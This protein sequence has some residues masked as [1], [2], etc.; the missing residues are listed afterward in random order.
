MNTFEVNSLVRWAFYGF[1]FSIPI[2]Y[3]DRSFPLEVHTVTGSLFLLTTVTQPRVCFR[4]PPAAIWLMVPYL[5][6]YL[7][8]TV[9]S[10]HV[11][12][13]LKLFFN[14]L[15]VAVLFWVASNLMRRERIVREALA[16]FAAGCVVI[17]AMNVLGIASRVVIS[18]QAVR[19]TVFGQNADLLGANMALG[20][21][22]LMVLAFGTDRWWR[23]PVVAATAAAFVI[24]KSLMLVSSRGAI[25]GVA[26]GVLA[27]TLDTA[28]V[29]SFARNLIIA[30]LAAAALSAAVYRS[31]SMVKR[32]QKTFETGSMSGREQIYPEAW[33][34]F[35]DR[36][37]FGWGPIDANFE[38]GTRT[39][40]Y[41]I[42][43][44]NAD[45]IS[46]N[47]ARE[48]HN[49]VLEVLTSMGIVGAMPIFLCVALS[50]LTAWFART[51]PRGTA[52]FTLVM[53]V[54]IMSMNINW[55]ASKQLWIVLAYSASSP[56]GRR[57][58]R[59]LRAA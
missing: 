2:E 19:R 44:H 20:L 6:M 27:F 36:P 25:V 43:Q 34:M 22:V 4:R 1:M 3:P 35:A 45:G 48:T 42:G 47:P 28:N 16:S 52:P 30:I 7:A 12:D 26:V 18:D 8:H 33:Q 23:L 29:R 24:A 46:A 50:V 39:A 11:A 51:G 38:L 37:L 55:A 31:G 21:V 9:F 56:Q 54:L 17:A 14:Y 10:D 40:G 32:Y 41:T 59:Q 57:V 58:E 49:L 5:W 53:V 13:S 15:L